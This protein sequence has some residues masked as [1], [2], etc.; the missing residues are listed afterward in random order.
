MLE[1]PLDTATGSGHWYCVQKDAS[2]GPLYW[3][4]MMLSY[5]PRPYAKEYCEKMGAKIL[6]VSEE[7]LWGYSS[8]EDHLIKSVDLSEVKNVSRVIGGVRVDMIHGNSIGLATKGLSRRHSK[9][10]CLFVNGLVGK[11]ISN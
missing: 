9:E 6:G 3:L 5:Y 1:Y 11:E 2:R 8:V 7:H 10:F 4:F